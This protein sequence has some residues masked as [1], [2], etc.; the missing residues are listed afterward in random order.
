ME[1]LSVK[2]N[3]YPTWQYVLQ[4]WTRILGIYALWPLNCRHELSKCHEASFGHGQQLCILLC[5]SSIAVRNKGQDT[6]F[7]YVSTV[8]WS[9]KYDPMSW[10][11][12]WTTIVL[13]F[14]QLQYGIEELIIWLRHDFLLC[15]QRD[16]RLRE[17]TLVQCHE[18]L[19]GHGQQLS[20]ILPSSDERVNCYDPDTMLKDRQTDQQIDRRAWW[21]LIYTPQ[22]CLQGLSETACKRIFMKNCTSTYRKN[23]LVMFLM[24]TRV[25]KTTNDTQCDDTHCCFHRKNI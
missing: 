15:M 11:T 23:S 7:G 18:T 16:L 10:H 1:N 2:Y 20:K 8:N 21:F 19:L 14:I 12:P 3:R 4:V 5:K 6:A 13:N 22:T 17:I 25:I 24:I 9:W